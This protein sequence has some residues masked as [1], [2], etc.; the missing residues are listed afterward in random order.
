[1]SVGAGL[2]RWLSTGFE[3]GAGEIVLAVSEALN[4]AVEHAYNG[5]GP[6]MLLSGP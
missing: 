5:P 4:N 3:E 6:D 1:M 2:A